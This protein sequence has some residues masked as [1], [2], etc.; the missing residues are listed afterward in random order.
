MRRK[1]SSRREKARAGTRGWKCCWTSG[2]LKADHPLD[3]TL[4]AMVPLAEQVSE[5]LKIR[6]V[7]VGQRMIG[8]R[9]E[10]H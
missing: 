7:A 2:K 6:L 3:I 10:R 1:L 4:W 9:R 5:L 8:K